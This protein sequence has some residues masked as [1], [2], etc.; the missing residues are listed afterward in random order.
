MTTS[1]KTSTADL[2]LAAFPKIVI[3][4]K[5]QLRCQSIIIVNFSEKKPSRQSLLEA[6]GMC[7]KNSSLS[8]MSFAINK[9]LLTGFDKEVILISGQVGME[10]KFFDKV[11]LD[12]NQQDPVAKVLEEFDLFSFLSPTAAPIEMKEYW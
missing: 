9:I 1:L 2:G 4:N 7:V 11:P 12:M 6:V 10:M 3:C 8:E 5:Y